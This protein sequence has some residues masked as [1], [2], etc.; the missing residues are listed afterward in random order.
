MNIAHRIL[1][2]ILLKIILVFVNEWNYSWSNDIVLFTE[3]TELI[4][5]LMNKK[6]FLAHKWIRP[7]KNEWINELMEKLSQWM[8]LMY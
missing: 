1:Y 7:Y 8:I 6:I 4:A 3:V 2:G 5:I